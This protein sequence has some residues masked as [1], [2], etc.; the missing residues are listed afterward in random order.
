M[1]KIQQPTK[2]I[3]QVKFKPLTQVESTASKFDEMGML[4]S[5]VLMKNKRLQNKLKQES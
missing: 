2:D 4:K 3:K 5:D 1:S